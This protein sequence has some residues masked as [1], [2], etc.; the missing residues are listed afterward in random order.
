MVNEFVTES[1]PGG[2]RRGSDIQ[3]VFSPAAPYI[4]VAS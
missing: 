4:L 2:A 1:V 3:L